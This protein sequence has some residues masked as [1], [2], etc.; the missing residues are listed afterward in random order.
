LF[1]DND[2]KISMLTNSTLQIMI[3]FASQIDAPDEHVADGRALPALPPSSD[4]TNEI[5]RLI[6]IK[7]GPQLPEHAFTAVRH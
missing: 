5:S 4:G 3:E 6:R 7:S 2:R 1:P